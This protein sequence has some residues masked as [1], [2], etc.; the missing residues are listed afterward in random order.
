MNQPKK[1]K[2]WL[3]WILVTVGIIVCITASLVGFITYKVVH[4]LLSITIKPQTDEIPP[5][6]ASATRVSLGAPSPIAPTPKVAYFTTDGSDIFFNA[7]G[8]L[9][10]GIFDPEIGTTS[11]SIGDAA[12][13]PTYDEQ[14]SQISNTKLSFY[15]QE[16]KHKKVSLAAGNYWLLTSNTVTI[17]VASCGQISG[18]PPSG[19]DN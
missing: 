18:H 19:S 14:R 3:L 12:A 8:F 5:C 9:H 15:V 13:L 7:S 1:K 6:G 11:L 16:G 4:D 17:T 2:H 10:G